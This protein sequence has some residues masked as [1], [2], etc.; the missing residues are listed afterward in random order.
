VS[1]NVDA[2]FK[3]FSHKGLSLANRIVMAPM[4]RE[5]SPGGVPTAQVADYYRRRAQGGTGLIITEGTTIN[6][7]V[8]TM[9][10]RI[11][12]FHGEKALAGWE[13]TVQAVH[14]AGGKIMPQLWHVGMAR[15]SKKAPYPELPSVG[16]SGLL[17]PGK[18]VSEPMTPEQIEVVISGFAS[19]AADAMRLGFDGVEIHGAHGYLIDQFFWSGTNERTDQWGGSMANRGRFAV[20]IIKRIRGATAPDFPIILRYSQW[21]Q[22]DYSARLAETPQLLE[23]FLTP[24]SDAGVDIFHCST[25]RYWESE[26]D[27]KGLNLAGW[28]KKIT[29]KP[30]ITVGSVGLNEDFFSA[31][32]G[33]GASTR[34]IDDLVERMD[35]GEF[36]L[37]AVGRALIQD[38]DWANKIREGK[39]QALEQYSGDALATLS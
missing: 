23:E 24:L 3:P 20:E 6:D 39:L 19:A 30:T 15:N 13:N 36:D 11:P 28:T 29:G 26:F 34:S 33:K 7:P 27:D 37:V 4:T 25:R 5:F 38:P 21:K 12:Q 32:A 31:F 18:Q 14:G 1:K 16:P 8:A 22:Q 2:L 35:K 9:G 17:A 10:E